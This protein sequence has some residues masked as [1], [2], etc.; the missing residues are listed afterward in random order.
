I[1]DELTKLNT[2]AKNVEIVHENGT[3]TIKVKD[4]SKVTATSVGSVLDTLANDLV[5]LIKSGSYS[6]IK[7]TMSNANTATLEIKL[8]TSASSIKSALNT[9][10]STDLKNAKDFTIEFTTAEG[11]VNESKINK[12]NVTMVNV[13]DIDKIFTDNKSVT[14]SVTSNGYEFRCEEVEGSNCA[15]VV[16]IKDATK[17][18]GTLADVSKA[19]EAIAET[20]G[21]DYIVL[22]MGTR[23]TINHKTEASSDVTAAMT[24]LLSG[25]TNLAALLNT[26]MTITVY[27]DDNKVVSQNNNNLET[28]ELNFIGKI[29]TDEEIKDAVSALNSKNSSSHGFVLDYE[30]NSD[31]VTFR[32]KNRSQKLYKGLDTDIFEKLTALYKNGLYQAITIN[33][34]RLSELT[35]VALLQIIQQFV[36]SSDP[37]DFTDLSHGV[38][39]SKF[40]GKSL[41]ITLE[42]KDGVENDGHDSYIINFVG[43]MN[44][45]TSTNTLLDAIKAYGKDGSTAVTVN[46]DGKATIFTL[47]SDT[48][49]NQSDEFAGSL[50]DALKTLIN[51]YAE[52]DVT[53][54]GK[55]YVITKTEVDGKVPDYKDLDQLRSD[56]RNKKVEEILKGNDMTI[57]YVLKSEDVN[58]VKYD[59]YT[60]KFRTVSD[61]TTSLNSYI[62]THKSNGNLVPRGTTSN[63]IVDN[64]LTFDVKKSTATLRDLSFDVEGELKTLYQSGLYSNIAFIYNGTK[65]NITYTAAN[66]ETDVE[67]SISGLDEFISAISAGKKLNAQLYDVATSITDSLKVEFTLA[68]GVVDSKDVTKD[69]TEGTVTYTIDL[70]TKINA[71]NLLAEKLNTN[72]AEDYTIK[73]NN[74]KLY[75]LYKDG[76][77]EYAADFFEN[78]AMWTAIKTE[79]SSDERIDSVVLNIDGKEVKLNKLTTIDTQIESTYSAASLLKEIRT[80]LTTLYDSYSVTAAGGTVSAGSH[81]KDVVDALGT[82]KKIS[83]TINLVEGKA[84]LEENNNTS[85]TYELVFS[86]QF[87]VTN[88]VNTK[89]S[90]SSSDSKSTITWGTGTDYSKNEGRLTVDGATITK[91]TEISVNQYFTADFLNGLFGATGTNNVVSS[92][93]VN[94]EFI[95]ADKFKDNYS[96]N[97]A[98]LL[99]ALNDSVVNNLTSLGT[100]VSK[101]GKAKAEDLIGK[102]IKITVTM[103][104]GVLSSE[105]NTSEEYTISFVDGT[106]AN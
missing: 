9:L 66:E 1:N 59:S 99:K 41:T 44:T 6:V 53:Y 75:V 32:V 106:K 27:L 10:L 35:D 103:N 70:V 13:I 3:I 93:D 52:I 82:N 67:E 104:N 55:T 57:K 25:K 15:L 18:T 22:E 49:N 47:K 101:E 90:Q 30:N 94:G 20:N 95:S 31:T 89:I 26:K 92:I 5:D 7:L 28:Y 76:S 4:A 81:I 80:G 34:T 33:G 23:I 16:D 50:H 37:L 56:L 2:S 73:L 11:V 91:D 36:G 40:I 42:Y 88:V 100:T 105:A 24:T 58:E 85:Y 54:N 61:T 14:G 74:G 19:I 17:T 38:E 43:N 46:S 51:D 71:G 48:L 62:E 12:Y 60:I 39:L 84:T 68:N 96:E 77:T 78:V 21:V 79:L 72:D 8:N 45:E 102:T 29:N 65:Y 98:D 64:K 83:L 63:Y 69:Y 86:K 87:D 97:M